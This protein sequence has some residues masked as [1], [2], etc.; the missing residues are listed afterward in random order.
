[1]CFEK[2]KTQINT[3]LLLSTHTIQKNIKIPF[4]I[5]NVSQAYGQCLLHSLH[6]KLK[7]G[8]SYVA[9][10]R[11]QKNQAKCSHH[12]MKSSSKKYSKKKCHTF[13]FAM[14]SS[15][16]QNPKDTP[17]VIAIFHENRF[18]VQHG[19][20]FQRPPTR[21]LIPLYCRCMTLFL[22]SVL[23]IQTRI[24][25]ETKCCILRPYTTRKQQGY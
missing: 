17:P 25:V 9:Q 21:F 16:I 3:E 5:E 10:I 13:S 22:V 11:W 14:Y 1:M 12:L 6:D 4:P 18:H 19:N 24:L 20:L 7:E 23:P 2:P 8:R 15:K